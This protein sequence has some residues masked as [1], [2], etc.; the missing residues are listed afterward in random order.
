MKINYKEG[1]WFAVPLRKG[2]YGIGVVAR[3]KKSR[4]LVYFFGPRRES[5]PKFE[6]VSMLL[7]DAAISVLRV[8][9]LGLIRGE[10]PIIGQVTSWNRSDWP[11]PIFIRREVLP[12]YR[13]WRVYF[14]DTDPTK[15]IKEELETNE[16]PDLPEDSLAGSG[17]AEIILTKLLEAN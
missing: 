8:G 9:H 17:A 4:L 7:S 12:P 1:T 16:R 10:W 3:A 5:I 11:M 13:N 15:R 6:E 14:S 2:G